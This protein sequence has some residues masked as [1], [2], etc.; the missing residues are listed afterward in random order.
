MNKPKMIIFD[1]GETLIHEL[2]FDPLKG[3]EKILSSCA[4]NPNNVSANEIQRLAT[5][6]SKELRSFK[7]DI[8]QDS[9]LEIHNHQFQNYTYDYFGVELTVTREESETIFWNETAPFVPINYI[10]ELLMYLA[11]NK[12]KIGVISNI[13]FSGNALARRIKTCFPE[14]PFEFI[15]SSADYGF[16]K[17]H[18]SLFD[19][20]LQK[21]NQSFKYNVDPCDIWYC[22]D[23]FICDV[24]G[25][26]NIGMT[27]VWYNTSEEK[28][29]SNFNYLEINNWLKLIEILKEVDIKGVKSL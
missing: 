24:E 25:A 14:I 13:S 18:Y 21:S 27:P 5:R 10:K 19:I 22:G 6:I 11:E 8:Y 12:I 9:Y 20:G 7:N 16:R 23:N 29:H 15:I 26:S 2:C 3:T 17:P 4:I 1:Y 28:Q